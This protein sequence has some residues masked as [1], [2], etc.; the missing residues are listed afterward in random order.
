MPI[1]AYG[2]EKCVEPVAGPTNEI[3][4]KYRRYDKCLLPDMGGW[5]S[6]PITHMVNECYNTMN[7]VSM[8]NW[9]API[10]PFLGLNQC[11]CVTDKIRKQY[12]C[13]EQYQDVVNLGQSTALV[14]RFSRECILE[15][16]MGDPAREAFIQAEEEEKQKSTDN[17]TEKEE[18]KPQEPEIKEPEDAKKEAPIDNKPKSWKD[19]SSQG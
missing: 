2:A 8:R 15:G 9:G 17:A 19:L 18:V 3:E 1:H 5:G 14:K 16:A 13:Q 7:S 11:A 10:H 6:G 4:N 12:P